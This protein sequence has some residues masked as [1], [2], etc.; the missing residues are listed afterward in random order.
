M[1]VEVAE[2]AAGEAV[3]GAGRVAHV[4][5]REAGQGEEALRGEQRRAVLAL[6]GDDGARAELHHGAGGAGQVRLAGQLADLG[7]V[8]DQAVDLG[9]RRQQRVLG[10]VDPEVHRVQAAEARAVAL[11]ADLALQVG[12]DVGEEEGVGRLRLRGELRLELAEDAELGVLGVGDVEVVLVAAA[13]EERLA[14]LDPLDVAGLHAAALQHLELGGAEVVA[15]RADRAHLG[16]EAGG[17][18]EVDGGAAQHAVALPERGL[19]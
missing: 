13:P 1:A 19:D 10:R 11:G 14:A 6:L 12:L 16:E 2:E 7:V 4:V 15:D 9:D 3:A 17:E 5:E 18:R 8:D